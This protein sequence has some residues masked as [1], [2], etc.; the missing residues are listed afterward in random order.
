MMLLERQ[1]TTLDDT[2]TVDEAGV[3]PSSE[4][5]AVVWHQEA[6]KVTESEVAVSPL[7][8]ADSDW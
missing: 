5:E 7:V 4:D 1:P 8:V 2:T 3:A 6:R